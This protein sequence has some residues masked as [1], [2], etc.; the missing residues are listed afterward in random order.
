MD[1]AKLQRAWHLFNPL[2]R[3]I[4][5]IVPWW[6]LVETL[7]NKSGRIRRT[8]VAWGPY[9]GREALILAVQG[10][11]AAWIRNLQADSEV[12]IRR[13]GR[14]RSGTASVHP[15]TD[16]DVARFSAYARFGLKLAGQDPVLVRVALR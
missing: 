11:H 10:E 12:R 4:A 6:W 1:Q 16:A 14:W 7:G 5:G 13:H 9:D 8:P 3:L 2:A 15:V